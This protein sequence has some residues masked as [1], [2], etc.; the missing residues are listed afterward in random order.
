MALEESKNYPCFQTKIEPGPLDL[1]S[2]YYGG[3]LFLQLK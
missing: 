3:K 1:V 2:F